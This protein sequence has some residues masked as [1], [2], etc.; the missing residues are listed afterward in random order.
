M[1]KGVLAALALLLAA[2]AV[3]AGD[4]PE[5]NLTL[6]AEAGAHWLWVGDVLLERAALFDGDTGRFLGQLPAGKGIVAPHRSRDG[7]ELYQAETYYA[8][9]TRGARTDLVSVTDARTLAPLAEIEIP[10]QALRAHV[11]GRRLRA[12][13]RR[14]LPRRLQPQSGDVAQHRRRDEAPLRGGDPDPGLRARLRRRTRGASSRCAATAPRARSRSMPRAATRRSRARSAS[15]TRSRDPL[16]EK[17]ARRG[18]AWLFVCYRGVLHTIDVAGPTLAFGASWPLL[19]DAERDG[20]WRIGGP[21]HLALHAP[22]GRL[23]ALVHQGGDDTHKEPGKEVW[24]YDLAKRA[25]VQQIGLREPDR[26]LRAR[27]DRA[28]SRA[29]RSTGCSSACCRTTASSA[30]S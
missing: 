12:V 19:T 13:G 17:G 16:I 27:A 4:P 24:V 29:A 14:P 11:V 1:R 10:R 23:Y 5:R 7:R 6:P 2:P 30:S 8:R 26:E 20:G 9:G 22:T 25:R 3:R 21:Q 18:E 15:S 28:G